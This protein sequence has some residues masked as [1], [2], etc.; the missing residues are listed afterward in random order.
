MMTTTQSIFVVFFAI[1][2]GAIASYKVAGRCF[3][4]RLSDTAM[5][6]HGLAFL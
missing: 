2:W 6:L 3:T 4:G 5:W 1:F